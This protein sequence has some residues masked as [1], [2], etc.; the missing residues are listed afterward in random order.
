M[1]ANT[2]E[3]RLQCKDQDV[4]WLL[5]ERKKCL[6]MSASTSGGVTT[7]GTGISIALVPLTFGLSLAG[8]AISAAR[9]GLASI[10]LE[11][12][13]RELK[14]RQLQFRPVL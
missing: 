5:R 10:K 4:S 7:I 14:E 13:E 11:M 6:W 9:I 2:S 1:S 3:Y 12:V 8:P